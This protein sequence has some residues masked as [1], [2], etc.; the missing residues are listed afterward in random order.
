[1][2]SGQPRR[3]VNAVQ[4]ALQAGPVSQDELIT[5]LHQAGIRV[6]V[7]VLWETCRTHGLADLHG[8]QW[9]PRGWAAA[10]NERR[11]TAGSASAGGLGPGLPAQ[12]TRA[13]P[14]TQDRLARRA[15]AQV[16]RL[17]DSVGL[18]MP[19]PVP[20]VGPVPAGWN[21][22]ARGAC[23]ALA[24]E[25]AK[26]TS[27]RT[28]TDVPL[29]DGQ[30]TGQ[31]ATRRLVR[32][33]AQSEIGTAEGT[34][35]LLVVQE[36]QI[37]V[38]VISVFG[39]VVTL[40]LPSDAPVTRE[41]TLRLDMSWLLNVQS[42]R[43]REL[44]DGGPGFDAAAALAVVT[45]E[46][47]AATPT[48][49][50]AGARLRS[51]EVEGLNEGQRRA[52]ELAL[53]H[54]VT[55]LWGPPG[56]GKTTTVSAL[57]AALAARGKRVLLA[58]P[59]NAALDVAVTS[60]FERAPQLAE[61]GTL[62]R[63]GQPTDRLLSHRAGN[64]VLVDVVAAQR[65]AL[66]AAERV[67][68]GRRL[69]QARHDLAELR[70]VK[71]P[72]TD[73]QQQRRSEL[74]SEA[75][76]LASVAEGLDRLL[77][78][79]RRKICREATI[80]A[81]TAHQTVLETLKE[82]TFDVVVLDEA[83]MTTAVLAMLVAG[84]GRGHTVIAGDF[85]QLPPVAVAD[86]PAA[87]EWLHKSP[88]EKAGVAR[89]VK[90]GR[91]PDRLAALTTQY[92]MRPA[93]G[94]VVSTAFYRESPLITGDSVPGRK[95]GSR[96][97]WASGELL[98]LD[99]S[100]LAA[101]T[102][103]RQGSTS[104]YN[105]MH[106]QVIAAL[107]GSATTQ[108][109][110]LAMITPF[111]AQARLLESLLI[112]FGLD[113][114]ASSTVHRFQGGERDIVIYDTVD[115]GRGVAKLHS[116]FT[117][118]DPDSTGNRLLNVAASRAKDHLVV[119]GAFDQLHRTG[120]SVDPLWRFFAHL[121]D[122]AVHLSWQEAID[123]SDGTTEHVPSTDVLP[124]LR[125]DIADA[126]AVDMWLPSAPLVGLPKLLPALRSLPT[127]HGE[128]Q[129]NTIWVGPDGDGYLP[130]EAL[131]A[132]REG[133]NVRPCTPILE[134][135]A[136]VGDVVWSAG[137]SLLGPDPGVVLRT[138]SPGFADLVRRTQ[139]RRRSAA[140]PGT[141]QLGDECG[142]CQRMLVRLEL[143]RR[144]APDVRYECMLCDRSPRRERRR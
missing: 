69:Q 92:R 28:E 115:T 135:S 97:R 36:L 121:L 87:R 103:R 23:R 71:G 139:R 78:Q 50:P 93:I 123:L 90:E 95:R 46:K 38:E 10:I 76:E 131:H 117:D 16:R 91:L 111:T 2:A 44:I 130:A 62:V 40:S 22:V 144:G 14:P 104:R 84:A 37:E 107:L 13:G 26:V 35:G 41:A 59:T 112:D 105:L 138:E 75:A 4:R 102:A 129:S 101:R 99:T 51:A 55:W 114:W 20:P 47:S 56:T 134:S 53:T 119:V 5:S 19:E 45:P 3:L 54:G 8:D 9:V 106:A 124:R 85:R 100:R 6:D 31:T 122:Q 137:S 120:S 83:S 60:L 21:E 74:E 113:G 52:V 72:L 89:A 143:P 132:R 65:G 43:L 32:F 11:D 57:V 79:F 39:A 126:T 15:D 110:D 25:L 109:R 141:G 66:L 68:V 30:E 73:E 77:A 70:R 94:H 1:M 49:P 24:D 7:G 29:M 125:E 82:L 88:F 81:A 34:R 133:V 63:L 18:G 127:P 67:D 118:L 96:I 42:R 48:S 86:T 80:V 12:R 58:A 64:A 116:W 61:N 17:A 136:V 140:V 33:E 27:R 128:I 142:R 98:V 108:T